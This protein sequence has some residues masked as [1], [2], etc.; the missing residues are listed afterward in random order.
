MIQ[1]LSEV[2]REAGRHQQVAPTAPIVAEGAV[3]VALLSLLLGGKTAPAVAGGARWG[4]ES[5]CATWRQ[6]S[7]CG[8]TRR[9]P[10]PGWPGYTCLSGWRPCLAE[11]RCSPVPSPPLDEAG[12]AV[13]M[14]FVRPGRPELVNPLRCVEVVFRYGL[15]NGIVAV[16]RP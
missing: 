2:A 6:T 12:L 15:Q 10:G 14:G 13:A 7:A 9:Q 16:L 3:A 8:S 4:G 5:S 11:P 1:L